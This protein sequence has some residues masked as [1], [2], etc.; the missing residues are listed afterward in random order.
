MIEAPGA[1]EA[2]V[3]GELH[4]ADQLVPRHPLLRYIEAETHR[5][6]VR[7]REGRHVTGRRAF[8]IRSRTSTIAA[9]TLVGLAGDLVGQVG[10]TAVTEHVG[11]V[12]LDA[13]ERE[14]EGIADGQL[15]DAHHGVRAVRLLDVVVV[16]LVLEAVEAQVLET[17]G[18]TAN[19]ERG[20]KIVEG[21][22]G[23][24]PVVG[25]RPAMI[26]FVNL[27]DSTTSWT[28]PTSTA[29]QCSVTIGIGS[30]S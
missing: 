23:F 17:V 15:V 1:V 14:L 16:R 28:A 18:R 12:V 13:G 22:L 9:L 26:S 5:R 3:L 25:R 11:E 27:R 29:M 30:W 2:E 21:D 24:D 20:A 6:N 8:L 7:D 19:V 10:D 4:A